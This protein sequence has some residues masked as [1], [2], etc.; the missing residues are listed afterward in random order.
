MT[1]S[2]FALVVSVAI[3]LSGAALAAP[4]GDQGNAYGGGTG[5]GQSKGQVD[6]N[7]Q[8]ASQNNDNGRF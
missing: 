8:G 5:A 1:K 2:V 3:G 6:G 7:G 4:K